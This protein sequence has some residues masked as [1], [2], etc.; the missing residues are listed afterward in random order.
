MKKIASLLIV[1]AL[2]ANARAESWPTIEQLAGKAALIVHCRA[3]KAAD[4]SAQFAVVETW[5]GAYTREAFVPPPP[6]GFILASGKSLPADGDVILIYTAQNMTAG[7]F[8]RHD[9]ALPVAGGKLKYP[10]EGAEPPGKEYTLAAFKT[11]LQSAVKFPLV[12]GDFD[13]SPVGSVPEGWKQAYHT[14][15]GLV[16]DDGKDTFL[17]LASAQAHN[18]GM[19]QEVPVP[20]KSTRIAV[21]GRIR[22]KPRNE[23]DDKRAAVEVALAFKD[24]AGQMINAAVVTSDSS[25]AWKT[26]R[27][28]FTLPPGCTKVDVTARSIFA[29]GT[30]DFDAVRVEFK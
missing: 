29:I 17:R 8:S 27:R 10:G 30:F 26:F 6:Q 18:A 4:G 2:L 28:E 11:A 25:A 13:A 24:A 22:G 21:L 7:K 5:K 3:A 23:K 16:A 1:A 9:M 19:T 20:E 15:G 14:G 12:N